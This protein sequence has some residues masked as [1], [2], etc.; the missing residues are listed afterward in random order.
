ME[1]YEYEQLEYISIKND[2]IMLITYLMR[3]SRYRIATDAILRVAI[4]MQVVVLRP[5]TCRLCMYVQ[6]RR[7]RCTY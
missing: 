6:Y 4:E 5:A 7:C 1:R 3:E 2:I